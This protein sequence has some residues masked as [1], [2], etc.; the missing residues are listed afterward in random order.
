MTSGTVAWAVLANGYPAHC[1]NLLPFQNVVQY[2]F[3]TLKAQRIGKWP[4]RCE[5]ARLCNCPM[6]CLLLALVVHQF[7]KFILSQWPSRPVPNMEDQNFASS[8]GVRLDL[9]I[10]LVAAIPPA[11]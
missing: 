2:R 3:A 9:E 6:P 11:M 8:L 10:D 7:A 4:G 5:T 1:E